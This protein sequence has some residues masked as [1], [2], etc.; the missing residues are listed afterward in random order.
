[1]GICN[2]FVLFGGEKGWN[3][4]DWTASDDRVRGGSSQSYLDT[5]TSK[6]RFYGTLDT[7]TL[8]GAGFASQ[9]TTGDTRSWNLSDYDGI[10]LDIAKYDGKRYTITLK[11]EILPLSPDGREQSTVSYEFDFDSAGA[12]GIFVPWN[13]LKANYRGREQEDAEP[14]DVEDVKRFSIM[15]RSFFAQ[16]EGP[17]ELEI[18]SIKAVKQSHNVE[19]GYDGGPAVGPN[20]PWSW[21][22]SNMVGLALILSTTWAMCFGYCKWKGLDTSFMTFSR[23]WEV[24]K[25]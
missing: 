1:M 24:V 23:W 18:N 13:A 22:S 8:G 2:E 10:H 15:M 7:T 14:L 11:D 17:F 20:E 3:A 12:E 19:R 5:S 25:K 6:A 21:K 9:R 4:S 16:Q